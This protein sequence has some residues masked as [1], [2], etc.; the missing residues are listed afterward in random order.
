MGLRKV[1]LSTAGT[2]IA[3]ILLLFGVARAGGAGSHDHGHGHGHGVDAVRIT[4]WDERFEVFAEHP[5]AVAGI[6]SEFV[7][8]LTRLTDGAPRTAGSLTFRGEPE[9]SG[10]II[11]ETAPAPARPGIYEV[12]LTFPASGMWTVTLLFS[13]PSGR[14]RIVLSGI[15]VFGTSG[16]AA[17]FSVPGDL[18]G[19]P[20]LKEQQ[21][22]IPLLTAQAVRRGKDDAEEL[23]IPV[24]A[25]YGNDEPGVFVQ[26]DGETFEERRLVL[27]GREGL[28]AKVTSGIEPDERVVTQGVAE[29]R[30]AARHGSEG[31]DLG[32][33]DI[34]ISM[35][36]N[37][38]DRYD[39]EMRTATHGQVHTEIML[40]GEIAL[41]GRRTAQIV[42]RIPGMIGEI[43]V[44]LGDEVRAGQVVAVLISRELAD[45]KAEYLAAIQREELASAGFAREER[46]RADRITSEQEFIESRHGYIETQ[47]L[48]RSAR[49]KLVAMGLSEEQ[50]NNLHGE[51]D[52]LLTRFEIR[53]PF[54]GSIIERNAQNGEVVAGNTSL[55]R[56]ADLRTVWLDLH[57]SGR[58][59]G[60]VCKGQSLT[61]DDP[62]EVRGLR[63]IIE[64]VHPIV[65]AHSRTVLVRATLPNPDGILRP[66]RFVSARVAVDQMDAPVVVPHE[67]IQYLDDESILFVRQGDEFI[68][69]MVELGGSTVDRIAVLSGLSPG[70]RVASRNSFLLKSEIEKRTAGEVGHGH[71][72]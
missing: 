72:H 54:A 28:Y 49:Q 8:H 61:L 24:S 66:G 55:F 1:I 53:S 13:S 11:E 20:F 50:I 42:A 45:A 21:W 17:D 9:E 27:G 16:E 44:E 67:A 6:P 12:K 37:D 51:P 3:G 40:P 19:I 71:A 57:A 43:N 10:G 64:Y 30:R 60:V 7:V 62:A 68:V 22:T 48:A 39:I 5:P 23:S 58:D 38:I 36:D 25:I 32:A 41:N 46:L 35:S 29:V 2:A 63:G 65:D 34:H 47:I 70:E 59:L 56:V 33:H 15:R 69:R 52:R 31:H 26:L 4:V 18:E 14:E